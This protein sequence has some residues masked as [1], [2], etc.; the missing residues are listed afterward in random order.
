MAVIITATLLPFNPIVSEQIPPAW[1]L[2]CGGLWLTDAVSNVLLFV[3]FGAALALRGTRVWV[4]ILLGLF[5]SFTIEW[6]Q[7]K[8][9]PSARSAALAD[10]LTNT[11]G[12]ALG[13]LLAAYASWLRNPGARAARW[14]TASWTVAVSA[15]AAL[16]AMAMGPRMVMVPHAQVGTTLSTYPHVPGQAWYGGVNESATIDDRSTFRKGWAG[17]IIVQLDAEPDT[18][19]VM[20]VVRGREAEPFAV[21]I[22]F[23]HLPADSSPVLQVRVNKDAAELDVTRRA[24]DWG[25]A[26][27]GVRVANAFAGRTLDDSRALTLHAQSTRYRLELSATEGE[28]REQAVV[29][30]TPA[31]GWAMLQNLVDVQSSWAPVVL[32]AWLGVLIVPIGW[33]AYGSRHGAPSGPASDTF[34]RRETWIPYAAVVLLVWVSLAVM[35]MTAQPTTLEWVLVLVWSKIGHIAASHWSETGS[36]AS[37]R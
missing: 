34:L 26:F 22:V 28:R 2:R 37:P 6:L 12:T 17:P 1:C 10:V 31:V 18:L 3:P 13:A 32:V 23:L 16:T 14:L 4:A 35:G 30:L 29:L 19:H 7:S 15:V 33:W 36:T 11:L 27:P 25:M 5:G 20:S 9:I 24:W 8:G 21:P